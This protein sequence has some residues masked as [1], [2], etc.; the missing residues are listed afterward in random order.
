MV[1]RITVTAQ[2]GCGQGAVVSTVSASGAVHQER[3]LQPGPGVTLDVHGT[4]HVEVREATSADLQRLSA[5]P[6]D[7]PPVRR[8]NGGTDFISL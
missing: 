3:L 4:L 8:I 1:T 2:G 6:A 5:R 7:I